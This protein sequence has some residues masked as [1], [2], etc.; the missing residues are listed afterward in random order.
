MTASNDNTDNYNIAID[1]KDGKLVAMNRPR[2][3]RVKSTYRV[4]F[5]NDV[6]DQDICIQFMD[7]VHPFRD[8]NNTDPDYSQ[9]VLIECGKS[10]SGNVKSNLTQP[11]YKLKVRL[12][13]GELKNEC[14]PNP[15]S[16]TSGEIIIINDNN[17]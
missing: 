13:N 9:E 4:N 14:K 3:A 11:N 17:W 2:G 10:K 16:E 12:A 1:I 15:H 7:G 5:I 6:S 8:G